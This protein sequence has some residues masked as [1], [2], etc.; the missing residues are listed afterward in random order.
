MIIT[1]EA[2]EKIKEISEEEGIGHYSVR[3]KTLSG[4]CAGFTFDMEYDNAPGELDE[5][6]EIDGITIIIDPL[7]F[8]YMEEMTIDFVSSVLGEGFKFV[9][10]A[11]KTTCAC[12]NSSGF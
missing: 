1:D 4:G 6:L 8:Q 10:G 12:G 2:K 9:G 3:V 5:I 11:V 7:S